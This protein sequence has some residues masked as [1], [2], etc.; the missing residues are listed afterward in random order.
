MFLDDT[1]PEDEEISTQTGQ[2]Q[3]LN[4]NFE[5]TCMIDPAHPGMPKCTVK[6]KLKKGEAATEAEITVEEDDDD[7]F[8]EKKKGKKKSV[9][10]DQK[11][12]SKSKSHKDEDAD[13][14]D[15]DD[16]SEDDESE[17]DESPVLRCVAESFD[18]E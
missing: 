8:A 6:P 7:D 17:D 5:I 10:K 18:R 11:S 9:K 12:K 3:P 16:E 14:D 15:D 1:I 13:Q 4:F 2:V